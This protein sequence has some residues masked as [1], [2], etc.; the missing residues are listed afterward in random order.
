MTY[1]LMVNGLIYPQPGCAL[2]TEVR[3]GMPILTT[4]GIEV[5]KVAGIV[6]DGENQSPAYLLLDR[7]PEQ[8]GYWSVPIELIVKVENDQ[9]WLSIPARAVN[10]F[11]PWRPV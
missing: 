8:Q 10:A 4:Q 6:I 3:R 11:A 7:L 2:S 1:K 5:G 9:L